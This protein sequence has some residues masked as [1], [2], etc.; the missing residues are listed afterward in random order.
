MECSGHFSQKLLK[1][2]DTPREQILIV[3]TVKLSTYNVEYS[4]DETE[5][6]PFQFFSALCDLLNSLSPKDPPSDFIE[7]PPR[8]NRNKALYLN[9]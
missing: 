4:A 8:I 3:Y 2:L 5:A 6:F 1:L 7:V 9:F